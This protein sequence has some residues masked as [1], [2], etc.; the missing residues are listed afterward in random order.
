MAKSCRRNV[1]QV[2]TPIRLN[3][4]AEA[5]MHPLAT[6]NDKVLPELMN[7]KDSCVFTLTNVASR[8]RKVPD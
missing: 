5:S 3:Q 2:P 1:R 6:K 4:Q 8:N 7:D